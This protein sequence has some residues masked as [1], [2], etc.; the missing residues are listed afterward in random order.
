MKQLESNGHL[1]VRRGV[2]EMLSC[3]QGEGKSAVENADEKTE[4]LKIVE[5]AVTLSAE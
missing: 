4:W 2:H 1:Q 5:N 3:L